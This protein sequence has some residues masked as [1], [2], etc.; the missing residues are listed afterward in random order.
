MIFMNGRC[1]IFVNIYAKQL[2]NIYEIFTYTN[3]IVYN[4]GD[5]SNG[6]DNMCI[7]R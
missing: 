6:I 5:I 7:K 1:K 2:N 4:Y 3:L